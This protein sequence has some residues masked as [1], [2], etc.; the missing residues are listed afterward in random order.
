MSGTVSAGMTS[1]SAWALVSRLTLAVP[2][3]VDS[4]TFPPGVPGHA[5]LLAVN[6]RD[7]HY[8]LRMWHE[9]GGGLAL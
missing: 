3:M 4:S 2:T 9:T 5:A 6:E 8:D 1:P 7:R